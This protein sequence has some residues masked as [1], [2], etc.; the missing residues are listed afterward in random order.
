MDKHKYLAIDLGASSGRL[1]EGVYDGKSLQLSEVHRFANQAIN[2][3]DG[4]YW[5]IL[6][7]FKEIKTGINK[8]SQDTIPIQSISVDTWGVDF[9]YLDHK[10]DLINN[11]HCYRDNRMGTYEE[12][13]YKLLPKETLFKLTGVQPALINTIIQ[14]YADLQEKPYLRE[15]VNRVLFI[16]DLINYMLSDSLSNE[17]TIAST[18][19]LLDIHTQSW[20]KE[21]FELLD[22]PMRWFAPVEMNGKILRDLSPRIVQELRIQPFQV[23]AGASHDTAAAVLAV[24][25]ENRECSAFI[26]SGT[27]SLVGVESAQP[28]LS[29]EALAAGITN[30]GC[31]DGAYRL[32][33]NTTG[34]WIVQELQRDW[35]LRGETISF[36]EMVEMAK[37][38]TD[39]QVFID[40]NFELFAS[41][42]DMEEKIHSY[43]KRR[44]FNA[45]ASKGALLRT[46]YESLAMSYKLTLENLERLTGKPIEVI[47]MVGGGIQNKLVCQLTADFTGKKVIAG[48]IEASAMGNI[49]SQLLTLEKINYQD[50][51]A[52]VKA[53]EPYYVYEPQEVLGLEEKYKMF[54][55][56]QKVGDLC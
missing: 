8:A 35:S 45:P 21:I 24:P 39:N 5:D 11:P 54:Q 29:D 23:I 26:S 40:P 6:S 20:S 27:W 18:S 48:P 31:F 52:I 49:L 17:Y 3:N 47:H 37:E 13:F 32:L 44:G 42:N 34:M 19:G 2:F 28:V 10:G 41:P 7:L 51:P 30:E 33:S 38:V 1:I 36:G 14:L 53:S 56:I 15:V 43:L 16:P 46:V 4:L 25:Y 50:I 55:Q 9:G 12:A 22:I